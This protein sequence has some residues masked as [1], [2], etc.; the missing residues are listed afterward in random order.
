MPETVVNERL[1]DRVRKAASAIH[2]YGLFARRRFQAGE[3]IGTYEGPAA[4]RDGTYVL[5]VYADGDAPPEA[6][7]GRNLLRWLN[8]QEPGNAEFDGFD[9]YART[10]I[11]RGEEITFDYTGGDGNNSG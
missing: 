10:D 11:E 4:R 2:G 5:W 8:H 7:S 3:Y 9:L 6:R 1:R